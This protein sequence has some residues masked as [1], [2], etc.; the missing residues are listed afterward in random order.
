MTFSG[1]VLRIN[2]E[3]MVLRTWRDG[4]KVI[5]LRQD[6]R[7]MDSGLKTDF[8]TLPVNTKVFVRGGKNL[9]NEL[10][11]YQVVWGEISGPH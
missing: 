11:A 5:L 3:M 6:T 8:A 9:E 2:P 4:E 7:Y 10:E 1:V